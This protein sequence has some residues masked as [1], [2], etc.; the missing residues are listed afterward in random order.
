MAKFHREIP[1]QKN[2]NFLVCLFVQYI[3]IF[4]IF[5]VSSILILE[6]LEYFL[7]VFSSKLLSTRLDF[8]EIQIDII[9]KNFDVKIFDL[10]EKIE[11]LKKKKESL[12]WFQISARSILDARIEEIQ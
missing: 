11:A 7:D 4:F 9:K 2:K 8:L 10:T 5:I 1:H 6:Y 12:Y 3:S